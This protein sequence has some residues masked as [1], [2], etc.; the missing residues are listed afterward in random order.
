[1][2]GPYIS[3]LST[4]S[5]FTASDY[6]VMAQSNN[7][8]AQRVSAAVMAAF[9]ASYLD[10]NTLESYYSAPSATGFTTTVP[11]TD[12]NYWVILTPLAG[13]ANGTIVL[14]SATTAA[15]QQT[16]NVNC[17]QAVTTLAIT[18][19]GGTVTGAPTTLAANAYFT[20]RFD[21]VTSTWYRVS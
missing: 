15:D 16:I 12:D 8:N 18:S 9:F 7:N 4:S 5:S 13:Y 3:N 21:A 14:P 11:D 2:A 1:M 10:V 19:S 6:V 20:L 17:T